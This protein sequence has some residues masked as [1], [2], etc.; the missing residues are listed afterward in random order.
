M[1]NSAK[2]LRLLHGQHGDYQARAVDWEKSMTRVY[3]PGVFDVFHI[4][5]LNYLKSASENGD[6]LIVAVQ[7]DREI[8]K[9]K[10][11][12]VVTPLPERVARQ[13][14]QLQKRIPGAIAAGAGDRRIRLRRGIRPQ[15]SVP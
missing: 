2:G 6:Y 4:G 9:Q 13:G 10:G 11:V 3:V 8:M 1:A 14:H 15:R 12:A 5:H 7:D